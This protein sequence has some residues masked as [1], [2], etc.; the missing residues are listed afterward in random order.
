MK[1]IK[2]NKS[3]NINNIHICDNVHVDAISFSCACSNCGTQLN[4]KYKIQENDAKEKG[5]TIEEYLKNVL[6]LNLQFERVF[7][8]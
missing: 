5:T 6:E 4:A 1:K 3:N 8:R 2:D 7:C